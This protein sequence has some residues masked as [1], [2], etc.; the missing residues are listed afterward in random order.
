[1]TGVAV[2][3]VIPC[4]NLGQYVEEAVDSVLAQT[5]QDLEI[6]VVN[7]GSTDPH[8]NAVLA[9]LERPR[10][11][12]LTTENRGVSAARNLGVRQ[13][14]GRYI[15]AL[16]ADDRLHPQFLAKTIAVLDADPEVGFVSTWVEGFG[17]EQ[18]IWRQ[19][20][21]DFPR[22][23][24]ECVVLTAS[25]VRRE[26]LEAVGGYDARFS[27][28]DA[29]WDVWIGLVERGWRG[30]IVPEVLFYYRQREGSMRRLCT[31]GE[32][33]MRIWR[34]LLDKHRASYERFLPEVLLLKEDDCGRL[35]LD[36]AR[37]EHELATRLEP[38]VAERTAERDRLRVALDAR[39]GDE[40][41]RREL[42]AARAEVAALR[43]SRSWKITAPL[44]LAWEGWRAARRRLGS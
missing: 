4:Y 44:R 40:G 29:D 13:A 34:G 16:D 33:R 30:A 28:G 11:R 23:L 32:P 2:S 35:L 3:V 38:L 17:L 26:A 6:V 7:D 25:P 19:E 36:N 18:W 9:G 39:G 24:A 31:R 22:L 42:A 27:E 12:V 20:R 21:C 43:A 1:M 41:L 8:T 15:V 37:I 14:R 10:M 5:Y